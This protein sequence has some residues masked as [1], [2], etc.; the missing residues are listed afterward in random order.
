MINLLKKTTQTTQGLVLFLILALGFLSLPGL[1]LGQESQVEVDF[2]YSAS[3]PYCQKE[4]PFLANL[5]EKYP[6]IQVNYYEV[7]KNPKNLQLM[8]E[9]VQELDTNQK[10]NVP[11]TVI[12]EKDFIGWD[13]EEITGAQ[14]EEAIIAELEKAGIK[15]KATNLDDT[16]NNDDTNNT[17]T[18]NNNINNNGNNNNNE[19]NDLDKTIEPEA[20]QVD[21]PTT[22]EDLGKMIEKR[23]NENQENLNEPKKFFMIPYTYI[24]IGVF[25]L[26][27][28]GVLIFFIVKS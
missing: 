27:V 4:K 23:N 20:N 15:I 28:A 3:C 9:A 22:V 19:T 16:K 5:E 17:N 12:G 24:I 8:K 26:G 1:T 6:Q 14:I 2:F 11:F 25:S 10:G 13:G 21:S 7:S 18:T